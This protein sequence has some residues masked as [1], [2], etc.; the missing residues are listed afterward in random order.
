MTGSLR[1]GP[2]TGIRCRAVIAI[3][4]MLSLSACGSLFGDD[5]LD[6]PLPGARISVLEF[7]RSLAADPDLAGLEVRLPRPKAMAAWPQPG[8]DAR[9]APGHVAV[10]DLPRIVWRADIGKGADDTRRLLAGP[11]VAD[12]R[13]YIMDAEGKVGA[14]RADNGRRVWRVDVVPRSERDSNLGGGVAHADGRVFV[15]TGF[16]QVIALDG[17]SGAEIWRQGLVAPMR[18]GPTVGGGRVLAISIDNQLFALSASDGKRL[19]NHRGITESTG[20]LGGASAALVEGIAIAPYS[21]GELVAVRA[22]SGRPVWSD[23][24]AA[25]RRV[26]QISQLTDIKGLPVVDRGRVYAISH[27]GRMVAIDLRSGARLWDRAIGGVQTPWVAGDFVFVLTNDSQLICLTAADGRIRWVHQLANFEDAKKKKEP[28]SWVGPVLAGDRL[29][30][31][32]SRGELFAV[33]PY[34]GDLLGGIALRE[35]ISVA[36]IIANGT[37]YILT[38]DGEL[39]ALR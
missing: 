15:T 39:I 2:S 1:F 17:A 31:G 28:I 30:V 16:A 38:D 37:I 23:T 34:S 21:S 26:D 4:L 13:V 11:V 32:N 33:S 14:Y 24:L 7:N 3:A 35:P 27:S 19:W 22:E 8:G 25:V 12:G 18:A 9:H 36:P 5:E 20:L 10:A 29:L 6:A